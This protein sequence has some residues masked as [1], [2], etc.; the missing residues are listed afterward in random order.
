MDLAFAHLQEEDNSCAGTNIM[1]PFQGDY[2]LPSLGIHIITCTEGIV[3]KTTRSY[4]LQQVFAALHKCVDLRE[5]TTSIEHPAGG[6]ELVVHLLC[7][8]IRLLP[9][10]TAANALVQCLH[11]RLNVTVEDSVQ[12]DFVT[13]LANDLVA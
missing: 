8:V 10:L 11:A 6:G 3:G 12:V 5:D 9:L 13:A 1:P 2:V 7:F 4:Y